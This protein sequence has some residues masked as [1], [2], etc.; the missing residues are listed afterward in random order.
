MSDSNSAKVFEI[1]DNLPESLQQEA[2]EYL[3]QLAA[4][5]QPTTQEKVAERRKGFG[6]WKGKIHIADDFDA[7]LED[8]KDYM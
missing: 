2:L 8:F 7:P 6:S 1:W 5:W 3:Q 4:S